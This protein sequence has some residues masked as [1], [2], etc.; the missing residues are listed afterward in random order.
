M[1]AINSN[2]PDE[3]GRVDKPSAGTEAG[4]ADPHP[5][6]PEHFGVEDSGSQ[7]NAAHWPQNDAADGDFAEYVHIQEE[8]EPLVSDDPPGKFFCKDRIITKEG[9]NK[10]TNDKIITHFAA[11][12]LFEC[13]S[14]FRIAREEHVK[15]NSEPFI[16]ANLGDILYS[17]NRKVFMKL[18]YVGNSFSK[19]EM[20]KAGKNNNKKKPIFVRW[21]Q[22]DQIPDSQRS[23]LELLKKKSKAFRKKMRTFQNLYSTHHYSFDRNVLEGW[24]KL[25]ML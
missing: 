13:A 23:A 12:A 3:V 5:H 19:K 24:K 9:I 2:I 8:I 4:P 18:R 15:F 14:A 1:T 21:M 20:K 6:H 17:P 22:M 7:A 11:Q 10:L 16:G 25:R